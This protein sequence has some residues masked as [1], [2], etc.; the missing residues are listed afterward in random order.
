MKKQ[1]REYM[2]KLGKKG[3]KGRL[4]SMTP[5]ERSESAARAAKA[6]WA[7]KREY[8][9]GPLPDNE[10]TRKL[11]DKQKEQIQIAEGYQITITEEKKK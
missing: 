9:F 7:V 11:S 6:R 8:T 2:S 3:G 1:L 5:E 10:H 4:A